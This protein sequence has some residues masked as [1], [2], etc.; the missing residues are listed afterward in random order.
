MRASLL[1][2]VVASIAAL[3]SF[4]AP[5]AAQRIRTCVAVEAVGFSDGG[6]PDLDALTRLARAA[7]DRHPTHVAVDAPCASAAAIELVAFDERWTLTGRINWQ[8]PHRVAVRPEGGDRAAGVEAALEALFRVLLHNDPVRLAAPEEERGVGGALRR[9]RLSGATLWSVELFQR[10][11]IVD[12]RVLGAPGLGVAYR[13]EL[14]QA[15]L[16]VRGSLTSRTSPLP[17]TLAL[18]AIVDLAFEVGWATSDRAEVAGV[19]AASLGLQHQWLRGPVGDD[20]TRQASAH[21]TGLVVGLRGGLELFRSA[22]MRLTLFTQVDLPLFRAR[23]PS[24]EIVQ[25]WLPTLRG[26][27]AMAL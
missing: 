15:F 4:A 22:R 26:G 20:E 7:L 27:L 3:T 18:V 1:A 17:T 8:V 12:R 21:R 19:L 14:A 24:G 23:G 5:A 13:R 6:A 11:G 16:G 25:A 2:A 10:V 9:L